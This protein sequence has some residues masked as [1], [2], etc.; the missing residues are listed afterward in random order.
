MDA[1]YVAV[2]LH[3]DIVDVKECVYVC[4]CVCILSIPHGISVHSMQ[5]VRTVVN[6]A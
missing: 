1:I 5:L 6:C 4:V 2:L 3:G